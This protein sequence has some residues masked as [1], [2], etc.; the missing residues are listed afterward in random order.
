[1]PLPNVPLRIS[2]A[3]SVQASPEVLLYAS[4]ASSDCTTV[5]TQLICA[6]GFIGQD[7]CRPARQSQDPLPGLKPRLPEVCWCVP[8]IPHPYCS[9]STF[10]IIYLMRSCM[11]LGLR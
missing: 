8:L 3:S 11:P 4:Y 2:T 5:H 10:T 6:L 7:R 9:A 1:M